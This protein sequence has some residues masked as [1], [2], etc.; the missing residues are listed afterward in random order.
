MTRRVHR[1]CVQH[2]L[3]MS[4][5]LATQAD[6]QGVRQ[7]KSQAKQIG[8][9]RQGKARQIRKARQGK[10]RQGKARQIRKARQGR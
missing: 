2:K 1:L 7:T 9:A 3:K 10:A 8:K 4:E 6:R 5:T